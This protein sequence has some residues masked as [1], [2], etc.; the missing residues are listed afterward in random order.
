MQETFVKISTGKF[1]NIEHTSL[2][3]LGPR[4]LHLFIKLNVTSSFKTTKQ[5]DT[6]NLLAYSLY[7]QKNYFIYLNLLIFGSIRVTVIL[8]KHYIILSKLQ[9]THHKQST[10]KNHLLITQLKIFKHF[11]GERLTPR[12]LLGGESS[13]DVTISNLNNSISITH[14]QI[15]LTW[16]IRANVWF[17]HWGHKPFHCIY[18]W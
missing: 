16:F 10:Y 15:S 2:I 12:V 7:L 8:E 1:W 17:I 5:F 11:D 13:V 4:D 6:K 3:W 14:T 9:N 18:V